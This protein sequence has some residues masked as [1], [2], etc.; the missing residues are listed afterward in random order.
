MT[1]IA[2]IFIVFPLIAYGDRLIF[3]FLLVS[4]MVM[5]LYEFYSITIPK[6]YWPEK[7]GAI[8]FSIILAF[9]FYQGSFFYLLPLLSFVTY[10]IFILLLIRFNKFSHLLLV[11]G[12]LVGGVFYVTFFLSHFILIREV[13]FGREWTFFLLVVIFFGDTAAY[14]TGRLWGKRKIY[15]EVSP[16]KTWVGSWG[17]MA[18]SIAGAL[19]FRSIFLP[20]LMIF[21]CLNLAIG[22]AVVGQLGDLCESMIKRKAGV[23]DSGKLL[24]GHGGLL[25]RMDGVMFGPPFLFYYLKFIM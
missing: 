1:A 11:F 15:P 19:I 23:K 3:F 14:Y 2:L 12:K 21:H 18:G 8:L 10:V 17:G 25:D 24:P 6:D 13:D 22:L 4:I 7:T 16:N 5:G 9:I 20:E